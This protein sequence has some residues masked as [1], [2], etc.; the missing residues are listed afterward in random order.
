MEIK[1]YLQM[2]PYDTI[3]KINFCYKILFKNFNKKKSNLG[4]GQNYK[5]AMLQNVKT[6]KDIYLFYHILVLNIKAPNEE[7][8]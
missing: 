6:L 2:I 5:M 4:Y 8:K 3:L 1:L 7:N